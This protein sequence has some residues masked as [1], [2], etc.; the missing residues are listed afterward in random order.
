MACLIRYLVE[1]KNEY[2]LNGYVKFDVFYT[3]NVFYQ[4]HKASLD[5]HNQIVD[6]KRIILSK[7]IDCLVLC[8]SRTQGIRGHNEREDFYNSGA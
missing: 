5:G 2:R 4:Y 7:I 8:G 3:T 6:K 1:I